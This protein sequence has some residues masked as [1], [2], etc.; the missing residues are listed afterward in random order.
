[1]Y[2][3]LVLPRTLRVDRGTETDVMATVHCFLREKH[4]DLE[5]ATDAVLYGPSTQNKIERWWRELL[6]RMERFF[7]DQ[8]KSLVESGEYDSSDHIDRY[9]IHVYLY[10]S[11]SV[12]WFLK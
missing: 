2:F 4:G 3:F 10:D 11:V 6:E 9:D 1:M 7:K 12:K 5:N 8:L